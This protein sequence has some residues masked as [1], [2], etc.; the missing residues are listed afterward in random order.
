MALKMSPGDGIAVQNFLMGG[1]SKVLKSCTFWDLTAG[2]AAENRGSAKNTGTKDL[3]WLP[4]VLRSSSLPGSAYR[5]GC[6]HVLGLRRHSGQLLRQ[7]HS[8]TLQ[9]LRRLLCQLLRQRYLV[10]LSILDSS[11]FSFLE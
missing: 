11:I 9:T 1:R 4:A 3:L 6:I 8:S 2:N 7:R 5:D 10:D